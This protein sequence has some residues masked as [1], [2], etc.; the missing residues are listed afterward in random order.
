[1]SLELWPSNHSISNHMF[2][3]LLMK[4]TKAYK[5]AQ[6]SIELTLN[7]SMRIRATRPTP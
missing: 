4:I 7:L 2:F 5:Q 6:L 1:M 3:E